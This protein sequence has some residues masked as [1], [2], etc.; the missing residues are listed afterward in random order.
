MSKPGAWESPV[1]RY[2]GLGLEL[3]AS[4][5]GLV[6]LGW[7]V[8]R[9]FGTEPWGVLAGALVGM[10]AGMYNLVRRAL[11]AARGSGGAP[12]SRDQQ[13]LDSGSRR[14]GAGPRGGGEGR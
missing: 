12:G 13:D 4:V 10:T 1:W 11:E 6:A 2:A 9:R 5:A 3:A 8:D 7:W 14:G